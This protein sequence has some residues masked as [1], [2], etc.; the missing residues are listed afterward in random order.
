MMKSKISFGTLLIIA[1]LIFSVLSCKKEEDPADLLVGNWTK[2][3]QG[4]TATV[5]FTSDH[6]WQVEFIDDAGIDVW[7]SYIISGNQITIIDEGGEYSSDEAGVYS[8]Q[9]TETSL[10]LTVVSDPADGRRIVV[11]GIWSKA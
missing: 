3:I 1:A 11:E 4:R 5:T 6:K 7:G 8:F 2:L 9:V 10:T